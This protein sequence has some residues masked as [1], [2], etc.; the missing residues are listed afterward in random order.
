LRHEGP[1]TSRFCSAPASR[2]PTVPR[3]PTRSSK[4]LVRQI[5]V[6]PEMVMSWVGDDEGAGPTA[7]QR[8]T[9]DILGQIDCTG[10]DPLRLERFVHIGKRNQPEVETAALIVDQALRGCLARP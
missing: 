3:E 1:G 5:E 8:E 4:R 7:V 10:A 2:L 9:R 6:Y